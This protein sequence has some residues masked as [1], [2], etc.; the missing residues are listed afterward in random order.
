MELIDRYF[1]KKTTEYDLPNQIDFGRY[2]FVD[3]DNLK[4]ITY[5]NFQTKKTISQELLLDKNKSLQDVFIDILI[6]L[7]K[8]SKNEF[9]VIPLIRRIKN[10]LGLNEFERL[11]YDK[12]FHIEEIF[13]VPHYSLEREIE[14]VNVSRAK[15][16]PSK[17]YQYLASHTED[18]MHKSIVSFKPTRILNEELELNFD[19]YE[20]Q[21]TIVL[22]ERC[23]RYLNLRLKEIQDINSFLKQYE[24][25][26]NARKDEKG[27]Y[28]KIE[29]N[30]SLIAETY[31]DENNQGSNDDNSTLSKTEKDLRQIEKR[32]LSLKEKELYDNV[33]QRA[34]KSITLRNT[35]VLVNHKHYRYIKDL[36]I[37]L[38]KI[39]PEKNE[40]EKL[41]FEQDVTNGL[42]AYAR[43]LI[44]YALKEYLNYEIHGDYTRYDAKHSKSCNVT[45]KEDSNGIFGLT[46]GEKKINIVV[47]G[48]LPNPDTELLSLLKKQNTYILYYDSG[49]E[50]ADIDKNR[51]IRIDPYDPDSVERVGILL[52]KYMLDKYLKNIEQTYEFEHSLKDY[53]KYIP[54]NFLE[55]DTTRYS[56]KFHSYP[57]EP[58]SYEKIREC[59]ENDSNYKKRGKPDKKNILS[60]VQNLLS[61]IESN[62]KTLQE[63]YL[64]CFV[65]CEKINPDIIKKLSYLKYRCLKC[66]YNCIVNS[67]QHEKITFKI[68]DT[69]NKDVSDIDFGMDSFTFNIDE[70]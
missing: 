46:I 20:N 17:S 22:V 11:L 10:K 48:N 42:R 63:D 33:N 4:D 56:Y 24:K 52:R 19:I 60:C 43:S 27:W 47:I 44:T 21:I 64:F 23:L 55:F 69:K 14:K 36:W 38:E 40:A 13:R 53:I 16:I 45:F 1:N 18:W 2:Y 25:L 12:L 5:S 70:I 67:A 28:K 50:T 6:D 35:N 65:C 26:L 7:E 8:S 29:R 54:K 3:Q 68:D 37:E 34:A 32:L 39:R 57:H 58:M 51:F 62:K 9:N 59:I 41:K 61:D 66:G 30:L 15:R 31:E 49:N